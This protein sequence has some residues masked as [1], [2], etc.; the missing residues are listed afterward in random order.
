MDSERVPFLK[1][2]HLNNYKSIER[3]RKLTESE[4][5]YEYV[6]LNG[7]YFYVNSIGKISW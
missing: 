5:I 1:V 7:I 4:E 2:D 3:K 6:N